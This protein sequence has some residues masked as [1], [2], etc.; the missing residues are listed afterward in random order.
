MITYTILGVPDYHES[1]YIIEAETISDTIPQAIIAPLT[2][3]HE[4][5]SNP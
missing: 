4:P 1:P 5:P 2:I 3:P